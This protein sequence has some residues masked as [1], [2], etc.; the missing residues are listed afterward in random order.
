[1]ARLAKNVQVTILHL[2]C[3]AHS[4]FPLLWKTGS[5]SQSFSV[6][7]QLL[8][9]YTPPPRLCPQLWKCWWDIL[10]LACPFAIPCVR[11]SRFLGLA[12]AYYEPC[13]LGF[14]N[15][16]YGLLMENSWPMFFSCPS[17]LPF[18]S[19]APLKKSEWNDMH[20]ITYEPCMLGFWNFIY[21]FLMEN[22]WPTFFF[23]VR[24]ISLSGIMPL[25]KNQN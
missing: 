13:M 24:V 8:K 12:I 15:F 4:M 11:P 3:T 22:S 5:P 21:G 7:K 1:M 23:L 9:M 16:I 14:W 19:Y 17:Y 25:W 18:W 2:Q 6:V 10:L 20:T